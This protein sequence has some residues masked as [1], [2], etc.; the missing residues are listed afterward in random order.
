M[1]KEIDIG[2]GN[3]GAINI[4]RATMVLSESISTA[5][6]NQ[7]IVAVKIIHGHGSGALK[8][9]VRSFLLKER[10]RFRAIVFGENYTAFNKDAVQIY[11]AIKESN[12]GFQ[13]RDFRNGNSGMTIIL[14]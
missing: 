2:H 7:K 6:T 4:E 14:L 12:P 3:S 1:L 13:D 5:K 8:R 10:G 11:N 9:A